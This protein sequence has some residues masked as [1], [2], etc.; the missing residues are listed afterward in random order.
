MSTKNNR[1]LGSRI[2]AARAKGRRA[3]S[4]VKYRRMN[5]RGNSEMVAVAVLV[6]A[7]LVIGVLVIGAVVFIPGAKTYFTDTVFSGM[8]TAT[9]NLFNF[10]A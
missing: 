3:L 9:E 6:I 8:K 10:K 5:R 4:S 7:V 1:K 2:S